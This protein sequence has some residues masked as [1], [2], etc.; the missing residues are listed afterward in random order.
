MRVLKMLAPLRRLR[1]T[2]LDLFGHTAER[3][4]ERQLVRDY[5]ALVDEL[6]RGLTA[7]KLELAVKLARLPEG[8]RG[9]GHVKLAT[10]ASVKAQWTDLMQRYREPAPGRVGFSPRDA[11]VG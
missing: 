6:L 1:G 4:L 8:I 10:V 7:T 9:Y 3:R 11:M 5:E 2:P